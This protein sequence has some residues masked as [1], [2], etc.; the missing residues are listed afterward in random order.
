MSN[1]THSLCFPARIHHDQGKEFENNL[2]KR[3]EKLS[4]IAHS[5]TTPYHPQGNGKVERFNQ[6]LLAMLRTLPVGDA[7]FKVERSR[8][9]DGT[10]LQ[11]YTERCDGM[12]PIFLIIRKK[13]I[14]LILGRATSSADSTPTEFAQ[15]W[16]AAMQEAY[17][18]AREKAALTGARGRNTTT[19]S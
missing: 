1:H 17:R 10:C 11:L 16:K 19:R 7:E 13:T 9:Q 3:L 15:K 14:D 18:I 5:Q 8:Q 2:F 6:T 4:G 12:R